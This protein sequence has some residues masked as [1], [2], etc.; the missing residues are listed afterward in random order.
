MLIKCIP[1]KQYLV[2]ST[3]PVP[4]PSV[5]EGHLLRS[6]WS[7]FP[8]PTISCFKW[9]FVRNL[10]WKQATNASK[11]QGSWL[12]MC[13]KPWKH[14]PLTYAVPWM[15]KPRCISEL[16]QEAGQQSGLGMVDEPD[17][18]IC[19][20]ALSQPKHKSIR[21]AVLL[22]HSSSLKAW[23]Q[24]EAASACLSAEQCGNLLMRN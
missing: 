13:L 15:S 6:N 11:T 12:E 19:A 14:L 16:A 10:L 8:L 9:V 2:V 24:W 4:A 22:W 21:L 20:D 17:V 18:S 7:I 3:S 23:P 1:P 5:L